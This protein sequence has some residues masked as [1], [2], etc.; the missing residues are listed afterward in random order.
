MQKVFC[1]NKLYFAKGSK[2]VILVPNKLWLVPKKL[3]LVPKVLYFV[4]YKLYFAYLSLR[5]CNI[6]SLLKYL[7]YS[8]ILKSL[9]SAKHNLF[10]TK[11][12]ITFLGNGSFNYN[13]FGTIT[14]SNYNLI[15]K[16]Y[17]FNQLF[18]TGVIYE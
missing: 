16:S 6:A 1:P 18:S 9:F 8:K 17:L 13:F 3:Y 4:P 12:S 10:G 2:K 15:Q 7:K 11:R 14:L 5:N